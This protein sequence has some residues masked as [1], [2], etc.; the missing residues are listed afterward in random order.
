VN[1]AAGYYFEPR[2][3]GA[4]VTDM[5]VLTQW[6]LRGMAEDWQ[7][8]EEPTLFERHL[9]LWC[10]MLSLKIKARSKLEGTPPD[11]ALF[12]PDL[13]SDSKVSRE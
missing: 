2:S 5:M 6:L 8:I 1:R 10:Q 4:D 11:K 9:E 3:T 13:F 12:H 7:L